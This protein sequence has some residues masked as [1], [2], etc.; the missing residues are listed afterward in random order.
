MNRIKEHLDES[1]SN[2]KVSG[3]LKGSIL[4][5]TLYK[6]EKRSW[7][8]SGNYK[9]V[10]VA[11]AIVIFFM[12]SVTVAAGSPKVQN[13]I[14][15]FSPELVQF[16]YPV[17]EAC[18]KAGIRFEVIAGIND[19]RNADIYFTIQDTEG[20][21]RTSTGVDF[22]DTAGM[23]GCFITN[24]EYLSYDEET[25]KGYYVLHE[26]GGSGLE[27]CRNTFRIDSIMVNRQN[28]EWFDTGLDLTA[29]I[30]EE[31]K[32]EAMDHYCYTG[33]TPLPEGAESKPFMLKADVMNVSLG[34]DIDFVT[35]S[36]IA[37]VEGKLH[38]QTKWDTSFDNH[39]ELWLLADGNKPDKYEDALPYAKYYFSTKQDD[40][41]TEN[42]RFTH[43]IEY[44]Y[45]IEN[46]QDLEDYRLWA[47]FV[48]DGEIIEG[49]WEVSF[50]MGELKQHT[51]KTEQPFAEEISITPISLYVKGYQG[52][53]ESCRISIS[54]TDGTKIPLS[55]RS[56]TNRTTIKSRDEELWNLNLVSETVIDLEKM[57]ALI[58]NGK[59]I[60]AE[61][62]KN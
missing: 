62:Q 31:P 47:N 26:S 32:L 50:R 33:G 9:S 20:K 36:N 22:M 12:T 40:E 8:R 4:E 19:D 58:V 43:H 54:L 35:I 45:D 6:E 55:R 7:R 30:K 1:L 61:V 14:Y 51:L 27:N 24:V 3:E 2:M 29:L 28:F 37:F 42:N 34:E 25:Q 56:I 44:V 52:T 38:I 11:A 57:D 10:G 53:P 59:E 60:K 18:E 13:W 23:D 48:K 49:G 39:G 21:G 16:L 46:L 41:Q 15:R 5:R 17:E